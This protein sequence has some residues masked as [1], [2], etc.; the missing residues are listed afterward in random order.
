MLLNIFNT[1]KN[2]PMV[3]DFIIP[4]SVIAIFCAV[5]FWEGEFGK[6]VKK[7][8]RIRFKGLPH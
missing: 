1:I 4:L 8:Y 3:W 5:L 6:T 7:H 2:L